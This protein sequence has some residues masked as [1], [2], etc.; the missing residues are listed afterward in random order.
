MVV[1]CLWHQ[2]PLFSIFLHQTVEQKTDV[3]SSKE[4]T[5]TLT[6]K[7]SEKQ[8][9]I[10][11]CAPVWWASKPKQHASVTELA[12]KHGGGSIMLWDYSFLQ[13]ERPFFLA[14]WRNVWAV[15]IQNFQFLKRYKWREVLRFCTTLSSIIRPNQQKWVL[16]EEIFTYDGKLGNQ[17]F[18]LSFTDLENLCIKWTNI[19]KSSYC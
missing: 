10:S 3:F 17:R 11:E 14:G 19:V 9:T 7:H 15:L 4:N 2:F 16:P 6:R 18:A 12:V 1:F 13:M 8:K 5:Q